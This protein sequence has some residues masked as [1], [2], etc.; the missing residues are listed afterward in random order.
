VRQ[1]SRAFLQ[2]KFFVRTRD[3]SILKSINIEKGKYTKH[4]NIYYSTLDLF[5]SF[6]LFIS[7]F[8]CIF[9]ST[10]FFKKNYHTKTKKMV[11][12]YSGCKMFP[13]L[14]YVKN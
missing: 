1:F 7:L 10:L 4:K 2:D 11:F 5:I 9:F 3:S 12:H 6:I 14:C 13:F 8:F